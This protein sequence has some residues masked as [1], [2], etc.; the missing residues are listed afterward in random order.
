M[1][2][3]KFLR[4]TLNNGEVMHQPFNEKNAEAKINFAENQKK[5]ASIDITEGEI[6]LDDTQSEVVVNEEVIKNI[7]ISAA[8]EK[9]NAAVASIKAAK[10]QELSAKD[11][12]I[13]ELEAKLAEKNNSGTGAKATGKKDETPE[14]KAQREQKEADARALVNKQEE[15]AAAAKAKVD[16][17]ASTGKNLASDIAKMNADAKAKAENK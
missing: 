3:Q 13:A 10:D 16:A 6:E 11:Q 5:V 7:W 17:G 9:A 14:E 4:T 1:A 12:R 15:E 8:V 2:K